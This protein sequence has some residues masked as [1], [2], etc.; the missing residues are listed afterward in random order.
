MEYEG[1]I[2]RAP[3]ERGA[4]MLPVMVGCS[5]NRCRFCMLFKHLKF[6]LL[7]LEEI[8]AELRRVREAGGKPEKIFLGD[9]NAFDLETDHL[10][11]ILGL[12]HRYFPEC[13]TINM[14]ATVTGIRKKTEEQLHLLRREGVRRLYIGVESGLSDVLDFMEKDHTLAEAYQ[15]ISRVRE[16]GLIYDAHMMTGIAGK[17]R[18]LENAEATAE[19][20]NRTGPGNIVNFSLF[21]HRS[22]PLY[23]SIQDGTFVPADERENLMEERRLLELLRVPDAQYDGFHDFLEFRVRGRIPDD[24]PKMLKRLDERIAALEGKDPVTAFVD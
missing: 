14:D 23:A 12:V 9:G 3:M 22:A 5:Y 24:I 18:G 2:C 21:L 6:R 11:E 8:E 10:L 1:Q 19:F 16:A 7:P 13:R 4:F 20:F 17:G 15:E